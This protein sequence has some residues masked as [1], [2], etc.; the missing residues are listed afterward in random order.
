MEG[1]QSSVRFRIGRSMSGM[2]GSAENRLVPVVFERL[3]SQLEAQAKKQLRGLPTTAFLKGCGTWIPPS[4]G[5]F[6]RTTTKSGEIQDEESLDINPGHSDHRVL[7]WN[8]RATPP[9]CAGSFKRAR[10][11][12][13]LNNNPN[14]IFVPPSFSVDDGRTMAGSVGS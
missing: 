12:S 6:C 10:S 14:S 2:S 7:L 13:T 8:S 5:P 4:S 1:V 9:S 3:C 11:A